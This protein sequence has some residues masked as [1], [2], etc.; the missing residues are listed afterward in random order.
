MTRLPARVAPRVGALC[1]VALGAAA[2]WA[3]VAA[4]WSSPSAIYANAAPQVLAVAGDPAGNAFAVYEGGTLDTP[5]LLSERAVTDSRSENVSLAW[6]SPRPLP[7]N[8]VR[9]TNGA[10]ALTAATAAASGAGAG[11]IVLRYGDALMTALVREPGQ[12]F[13]DPATIAGG[14][15]GRLDEPSVTTSDSGAT[16]LAFHAAGGRSGSGRVLFSYR[17]PGGPFTR[18]GALATSDGPAPSAAQA[19]DGWP[20]IA[21]TNRA[22][23]YAA[24]I[25]AAGRPTAPQRLGDTQVRGPLVAAVGHGGD[26]VVAWIDREGYLRLVRRSAPGAFSLSLP[27]HRPRSGTAMRDLAAAVD[28]L[29]RAFVTWRETRGAT[30]RV[31]VAQAPVGGS[32]RI[33]RLA[34]GGDVGPPVVASRPDGGAAIA[35]PSAAG[36]KAVVS[37]AAKFGTPGKASDALHGDDLNGAHATLI[38]GPGPR[39]E[40]VWRQLGEIEPSTGPVVYAAADAGT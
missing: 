15:T 5:L 35:W 1:A 9:F 26:G 24:R 6:S 18:L 29:G 22:T 21:W 14:T 4:A 10:P 7:G 16:L 11:A 2:V 13:G 8:V 20:V 31:Y 33:T 39:V 17:P 32:F 23:A 28:P 3:G 37:T 40:L 38:T 34:A 30:R 12:D 25:S 36:W 19:D 27:I